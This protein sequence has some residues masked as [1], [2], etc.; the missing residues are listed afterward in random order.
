MKTRYNK[1]KEHIGAF[2]KT[3]V[4]YAVA[5]TLFFMAALVSSC[6]SD[7]VGDSYYTFTEEMMGSYFEERP[8]EFSEFVRMLDTTNV[9]GL[10]NAYGDYTCFA[11]N[12]EA[13][14]AFYASKGRST[15][16]EFPYDTI[17]KIVYDHIIKDT[18]V[19]VEDF[20]EGRLPYLTMSNRY[21]SVSFAN[22]ANDTAIITVNKF[23]SILYKDKTVHNGVIHTISEV[24]KPTD[25]T[26]VEALSEDDRYNLFSE[27][28]IETGLYNQLALIRDE[29]YDVDALDEGILNKDIGEVYPEFKKYGYT[30]LVESDETYAA[31]GITNLESMANYAKKGLR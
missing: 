20:I 21:V 18:E 14:A 2:T 29:S 1:T 9:L 31:A 12:N 28:L 30:A 6:D 8:E 16:E 17:V 11:P 23:A 3:S 27:A 24:L 26:L 5:I 22:Y 10:L 4:S 7:D 19:K 13:V 15:L 25:K